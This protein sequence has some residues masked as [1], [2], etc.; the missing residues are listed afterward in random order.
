LKYHMPHLERSSTCA[1]SRPLESGTCARSAKLESGTCARSAK[2]GSGIGRRIHV[3]GNTSAGKSTLAL[4]L[5][6]ALE[7]PFVELDALNWEPDW[8]GL[9]DVDPDEFERRIR[10]ATAGDSWVVAGSYT[11]FSQRAFW[12]RLQT[13]IWLDLPLPQL[14]WRVLAR[15]WR[16]WRSRELLWGTNYERFWP[17]LMVWRKEESLVWWLVTQHRRKRR[18]MLHYMADPRWAHIRFVRLTS[19]AEVELFARAV[20]AVLAHPSQDEASTPRAAAPDGSKPAR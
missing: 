5:A 16:R 6:R 7:V 8:V 19:S 15:S 13:V 4:R 2:Q 12:P 14:L 1:R 9:H 18:G 10:E 20:E 11:G 3:I 17:Q